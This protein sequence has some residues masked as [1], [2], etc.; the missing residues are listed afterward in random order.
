M[1]PEVVAKLNRD[2][3]RL[4]A[5]FPGLPPRHFDY[6][7]QPIGF[8]T[9]A[10]LFEEHA[11]R[12]VD[13]TRVSH[14]ITVSTVWLGLDHNFGSGGPPLIYETM[15]FGGPHDDWQWRYTTREQAEAGHEY[16]VRCAWGWRD[17]IVDAL[18]NFRPVAP[19]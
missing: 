2:G 5:Q 4:A 17:R 3:E 19:W 8:G 16:A 7:C 12:V 18:K 15:I 1:D 9:W 13:Y 11:Q 6:D 10:E 14:A